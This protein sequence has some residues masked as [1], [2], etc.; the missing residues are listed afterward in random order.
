MADFSGWYHGQN[1]RNTPWGDEDTPALVTAVETA[2]ERELSGHIMRSGSK[3]KL[4]KVKEGKLLTEQ[5]AEGDELYLL[6]D[7][8]LS[9]EVDGEAGGRARTG[10][11]RR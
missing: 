6:L 8:V 10:C 5:G 1:G 4:R 3:P 2:L 7:G 9:V 11:D